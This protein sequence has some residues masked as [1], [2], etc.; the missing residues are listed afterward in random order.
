MNRPSGLSRDVLLLTFCQALMYSGLSLIVATSALVG[1]ALAVDKS[2]ATLPFACQL[3]AT[4][5]TSLPAG[6]LMAR[7]GRK[8]AFRYATLL[9]MVGGAACTTA[10]VSGSFG[11]FTAGCV[12][13]GMFAGFGN[14][15]RFAAAD[16]VDGAHR[17]R[18]IGYV[19]AGGVVAAFVGPNLANL[20]R[21]TLSSAPF[22][23]SYASLVVLYVLSL[24]LLMFLR[25]PAARGGEEATAAGTGR[26][27]GEIARQPAFVVAVV[28][29]ALGYAVMT[30][31]MTATPLAMQHHGHAFSDSSFVIQWHV[32]GMFA[33]SFFTGHLINRFGVL[34]IMGVGALAA[35]AC[36]GINLSGHAVGN[37]W[38]A[39]TLLGVGW[40][41]LFIGATTLLTETYRR[42]ERFKTQALNDFIVFSTVTA[43]SLSSGAIQHYFGWQ[44]VNYGA[45][46]MLAVVLAALGWLAC[47]RA[48]VGVPVEEPLPAAPVKGADGRLDT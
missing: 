13:L 17:S 27:L 46:P 22:A 1:H 2:Y 36:V 33:P 10:I 24:I 34:R 8:A 26:G 45:L 32:L 19:M 29:G 44:T 31:V 4:M 16:S 7:I 40:N 41:F 14:F 21:E 15:Y 28:S 35:L 39:L 30:L 37:F 42:A 43:A 23:G 18:A 47:R 12:F 5:L 3:L 6:A 25:L 20:T 48:T 11:L 38:L 9:G